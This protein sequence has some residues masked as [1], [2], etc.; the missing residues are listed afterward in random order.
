M[1]REI[2]GKLEW[3]DDVK[4]HI[5]IPSGGLEAG[6]KYIPEWVAPFVG[7]KVCI[8]IEEVKE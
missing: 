1:K 8:T 3:W 4:M 6:A 2:K 5:V 7:K